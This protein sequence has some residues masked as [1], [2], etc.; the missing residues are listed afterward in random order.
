MA[1]L[2]RKAEIEGIST[3]PRGRALP[4]RARGIERAR[5]RGRADPARRPRVAPSVTRSRVDY[6]REVDAEPAPGTT[7]AGHLRR[8][9]G[10]GVRALRAPAGRSALAPAQPPRRAAT[11]GR[12]VPLPSA[13]RTRRSRTSASS[14]QRDHSTVI[15][16]VT[17]IEQRV[18]DDPSFLLTVE[19]L[20]RLDPPSSRRRLTMHVRRC[21]QRAGDPLGDY[22]SDSAGLSTVV[23]RPYDD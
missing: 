17:T 3:P 8:H 10:R 15:H 21:G 23:H 4:G 22:R 19:Q 1:I 9:R 7:V 5:A 14:S 18:K 6:A 16:G 2:E 13:A 12:D 20:E 11:P